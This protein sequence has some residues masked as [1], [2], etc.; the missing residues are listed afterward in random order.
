MGTEI[1]KA[2]GSRVTAIH[3]EEFGASQSQTLAETSTAGVV[4]RER[5]LIEARY[6]YSERHPRNWD[7]VRVRLLGHCDRPG[8]AAVS[9][10]KKPTGK[11][12]INGQ[13]IETFAEGLSARFA[14]VARQEMGNVIAESSVVYEDELMRIVRAGVTDLERN[15]IES[16]EM[17]IAKAVERRGYQRNGEWLP[18]DGREILATRINSNGEPVYLVRAT[19]DE[20]HNKQNSE[21]SKIQRDATLRLIPKDIRDECEER[22]I[23]VLSDPKKVDPTRER[24]RVVDAF[25][26]LGVMPEDLLTYTNT[27]VDRLSPAQ[28]DDLRGLWSAIN[29]GQTTF[30]E[31]LRQRYDTSEDE[32]QQQHDERL[33]RQMDEQEQAAL[34]KQ[35]TKKEESGNSGASPDPQSPPQSTASSA[36]DEPRDW[37]ERPELPPVAQAFEGETVTVGGVRYRFSDVAKWQ[38][39][40]SPRT[41]DKQKLG[42]GRGKK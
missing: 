11:K 24:K 20:V 38:P 12:K 27:P 18:P 7:G 26:R 32:N 13:W 19:E 14:E 25:A 39:V 40:E 17:P 41:E 5:A 34:A 3:R 8:F 35:D 33:R 4:A 22:T 37:G 36:S 21:V 31:A 15:A 28:L 1:V 29:E 16:R 23:A 42:F 9:R 6:L 30:N 10:Y 2:N